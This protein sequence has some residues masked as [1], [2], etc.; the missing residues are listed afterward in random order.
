[1]SIVEITLNDGTRESTLLMCST[2][3]WMSADCMRRL[4]LNFSHQIVLAFG[5]KIQKAVA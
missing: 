5:A 4:N 3:F 1:L 2:V